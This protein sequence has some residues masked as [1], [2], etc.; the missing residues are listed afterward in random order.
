MNKHIRVY[1]IKENGVEIFKGTSKEICK[2]FGLN[3][4]NMGS[5]TCNKSLI[6]N[7][8]EVEF[9]GETRLENIVCTPKRE[10]PKQKSTIDY[11]TEHLT[12]YGN[13]T[14]KGNPENYREQLKENGIE[15]TYWKS[16][17]SRKD[18]ILERI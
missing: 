3:H 18:Y 1:S 11:L 5:Y 15:F 8:Y 7:K 10:K 13:T 17:G 12:K 4:A 2:H 16:V 9:N 14:L 6:K